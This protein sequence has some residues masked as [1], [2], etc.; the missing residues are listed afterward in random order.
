MP[1]EVR[2]AAAIECV[3]QDSSLGGRERRA[4]LAVALWPRRLPHRRP[5]PP[6]APPLTVEEMQAQ[7]RVAFRGGSSIQT[8]ADQLGVTW[9]TARTWT[10]ARSVDRTPTLSL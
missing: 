4:L 10:R 5:L 6:Q 8:I 7:A 9:M 1:L 3:W 2:C